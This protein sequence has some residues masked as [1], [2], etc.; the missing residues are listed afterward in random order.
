MEF[1]VTRPASSD[2]W[3]VEVDF[4]GVRQQWL[5]A[6]AEQAG[7]DQVATVELELQELAGEEVWALL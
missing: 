3:S 2:T 5:E 1:R 6:R 4:E 7:G